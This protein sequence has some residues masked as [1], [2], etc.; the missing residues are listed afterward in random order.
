MGMGN[1]HRE[2]DA[3]ILRR[4]LDQTPVITVTGKAFFDV[5]HSLKIKNQTGEAIFPAMLRGKFTR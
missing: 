3:E 2:R 1:P 4:A 5:G